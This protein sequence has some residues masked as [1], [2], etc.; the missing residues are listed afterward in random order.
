MVLQQFNKKN[1]SS[2]RMKID[3]SHNYL[4]ASSFFNN[5]VEHRGR[6]IIIAVIY[7]SLRFVIFHCAATHHI[8]LIRYSSKLQKFFFFFLSSKKHCLPKKQSLFLFF[9]FFATVLIRSFFI[10]LMSINYLKIFYID[11]I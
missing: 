5:F 11:R 8:L 3:G 10:F 2:C 9:F 1:C 6:E 4:C 7:H